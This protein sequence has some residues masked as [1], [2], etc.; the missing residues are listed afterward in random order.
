[1]TCVYCR[2]KEGTNKEMMG[3]MVSYRVKVKL[4]VSLAGYENLL[5]FFLKLLYPKEVTVK[6]G[7]GSEVYEGPDAS[8][9][10]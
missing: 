2:V 10:S 6:H 9:L 7:G 1:M 8:T 5:C 4:V 3:I